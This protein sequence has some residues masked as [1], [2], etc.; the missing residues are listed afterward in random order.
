MG[1]KLFMTA[2]DIAAAMGVSK[3]YAYKVIKQLNAELEQ[4]GY[5]TMAGRVNARYFRKK[6]C[7][8]EP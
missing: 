1:D 8:D 3:S 7:Y 6:V 4:K 5:L 2:E